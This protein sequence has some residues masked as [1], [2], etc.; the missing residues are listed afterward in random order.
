MQNGTGRCAVDLQQA[1]HDHLSWVDGIL[2]TFGG[3]GY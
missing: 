2:P 3:H 1:N